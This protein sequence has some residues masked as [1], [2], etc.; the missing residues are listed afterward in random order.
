MAAMVVHFGTD[1]CSRVL[2]LEH[3]GYDVDHCPSLVTLRST[4]KVGPQP[5][6]VVMTEDPR[7]SRREAISLVRSHSVAPLVL[8]QTVGPTVDESEFDL[9]IPVLTPPREWLEK[10]AA[11]IERSHALVAES[12]IARVQSAELR[13]ES[14]AA[15]QQ[16]VLER[17]R[18][19]RQRSGF[20]ELGFEHRE[21]SG[22]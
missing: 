3:A 16:S 17:E 2:V 18:S 6:A 21:K 8:F 14:S 9:V 1:S 19:V 4:L 10:I 20:D 13:L 11:T 15:R 7:A 12:M 22:D 5:D